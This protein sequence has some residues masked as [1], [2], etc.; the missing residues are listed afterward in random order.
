[1]SKAGRISNIVLGVGIGILIV[2]ILSVML[3]YSEQY[4]VAIVIL[5]LCITL[6][7]N[8]IRSLIFYGNMARHMVGGRMT[9]YRGLIL[10]D[11]GAFVLATFSGTENEVIMTYILIFRAV[12]GIIALLRMIESKKTGAPW[13]KLMITAIVNI[14]CVVI[15][16]IFMSSPEAVVLI[17]CI[18]LAASAIARIV[19]A[20]E[21]T[22]IV[23]IA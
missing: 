5:V 16:S 4:A 3:L 8:G 6:I 19:S 17:Y 1:M 23:Y 20:F 13:R 9:L 18:G 2:F 11:L 7:F 10:L 15:G 22:A 14:G 21:K 12:N